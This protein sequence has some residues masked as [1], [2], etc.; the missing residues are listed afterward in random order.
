MQNA[1]FV[2]ALSTILGVAVNV[3]VAVVVVL[4][5]S[6]CMLWNTVFTLFCSENRAAWANVFLRV[7]SSLFMLSQPPYHH[8]RFLSLPSQLA[9]SLLQL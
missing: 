8:R 4:P 1:S 7:L 6:P 9:L 2:T 5:P 3:D